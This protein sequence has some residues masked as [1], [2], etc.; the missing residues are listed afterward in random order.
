MGIGI[1]N[2][3]GGVAMRRLLHGEAVTTPNVDFGPLGLMFFFLSAC[4]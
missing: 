4:R 2:T 3:T 1:G